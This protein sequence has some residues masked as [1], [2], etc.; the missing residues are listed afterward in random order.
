M[1]KTDEIVNAA[2]EFASR[3]ADG[4]LA[5]SIGTQLTCTEVEVLADCLRVVG[6]DRAAQ[7]WIDCHSEQDDC[8]DEHCRCAECKDGT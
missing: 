4:E 7:V 2:Y 1:G 6:Y 3:F 8:G 5:D